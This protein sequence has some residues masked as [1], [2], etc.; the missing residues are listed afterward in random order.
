M[1]RR[2]K[3]TSKYIRT[4]YSFARSFGRNNRPAPLGGRGSV[5]AHACNV[6]RCCWH[7]QYVIPRRQIVLIMLTRIFS[8]SN[9][10]SFYSYTFVRLICPVLFPRARVSVCVCYLVLI[11]SKHATGKILPLTVRTGSHI[12]V[13][14]ENDPA[15]F[16]P[17]TQYLMELTVKT[18]VLLQ[19][20]LLIYM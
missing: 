15:I 5:K 20:S 6:T 4:R 12:L 18:C 9:H 19:R 1:T 7:E 11:G 8:C 2:N 17:N 3:C 13:T 10:G 16:A 14:M